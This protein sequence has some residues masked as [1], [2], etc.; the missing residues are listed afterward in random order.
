M[1]VNTATIVVDV[2]H[3]IQGNL[4]NCLN[5]FLHSTT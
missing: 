4:E 5:K 3:I 2:I 1:K